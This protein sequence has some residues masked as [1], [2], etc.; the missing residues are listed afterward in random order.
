MYR[1]DGLTPQLNADTTGCPVGNEYNGNNGLRILSVFMLLISSGI[2]AFFPILAS[3]YSFVKLPDWCFFAA[4]HFG[5]GVI[6]VTGFLHLL[7]PAVYSLGQEC[8]G[9]TF[10]EYPWAFGICLMSLFALF[11]VEIVT[12]NYASKA[13]EK[14]REAE[15]LSLDEKDNRKDAAYFDEE[16]AIKETEDVLELSHNSDAG[17]NSIKDI[18]GTAQQDCCK[19]QEVSKNRAEEKYLN[20]MISVSILEFGIV[21]HSVFIGL[22]LAVAGDEFKTLF[23]VLIF[24]QMFEGLGLGTRIAETDWPRNRKYTPWLFALAFTLCTPVAVAVGLGVRHSFAPFSRGALLVNGICDAI[25]S[26]I[27]IYTGVADLMAHEFF[28]SDSFKGTDSFKLKLYAYFIMCLGAGI[29]ALI[30]KWA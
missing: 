1:K 11:F 17:S 9:G 14:I 15:E 13:V 18:D 7:Q 12:H 25:S 10:V 2:G 4:K 20:Q 27:L 19:L 22:S 16:K 23:V 29:M 30:G 6:I 24:H 5:S 21:F 28:H 8:L 26:G 3:K